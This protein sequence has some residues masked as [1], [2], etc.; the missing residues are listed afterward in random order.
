MKMERLM[1]DVFDVTDELGPD[2]VIHI[3]KPA[4]G[5]KA[6]L[7]VD[8]VA[9]GPAIATRNSSP[10]QELR[11]KALRATS[12]RTPTACQKVSWMRPALSG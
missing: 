8:N 5:L 3:S 6:I 7:V 9:A 11:P 12:F 1:H 4:A 10:K 2:K